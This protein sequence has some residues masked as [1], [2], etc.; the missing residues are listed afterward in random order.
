MFAEDDRGTDALRMFLSLVPESA[1]IGYVACAAGS[2]RKSRPAIAAHRHDDP[3]AGANSR[4]VN[5]IA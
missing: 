2:D 5:Q 4:R 1:G 3:I